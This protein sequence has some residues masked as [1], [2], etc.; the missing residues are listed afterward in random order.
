MLLPTSDL[1]SSISVAITDPS[2]IAAASPVKGSAVQGNAGAAK[3]TAASVTDINNPNLLTP[4]TIEFTSPTTYTV[5]GGAPQIWTPGDLIA[6]NGWEITLDSTVVVAGDQFTVGPTGPNSSDNSNANRL[7]GVERGNLFGGGTIS[8]NA[9]VNGLTT[10]VGSSA[11]SAEM[12]ATA[13]NLLYQQAL[14]ARDAISGV[15]EDEEL[16]NLLMFQHSYQAAAQLISTA[17]TL[18][19]TI[20]AAT[21]R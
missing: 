15:N 2:R 16:A 5:N 14:D 1:A 21:R 10:S 19:Q 3:V 17:D 12:S 9:A 18:F 11:R 4:V 8:L 13:Q 7:A 6:A 20:L